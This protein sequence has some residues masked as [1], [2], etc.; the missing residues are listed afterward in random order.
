VNG[1]T[2][3]EL[4]RDYAERREEAAFAEFVRRHVD[5]VYSAALR[6]VRDGHLAEDVTQGVFVACAQNAR[7][8]SSHG[9]LLGWLHR[10]AQNLA[11][12]TVRS[13]V[14]RRAR[15]QEAMAMHELISPAVDANWENIA[16]QL[17]Q[18]LGEL[19]E[20][21]RDALWLHFFLRKSARE[22]GKTLGISDEAAQKRVSR[23]VERL[24]ELFAKRGVTVGAGGL[25]VALAAN[26]VQAAP[27]GLAAAITGASLAGTAVVSTATVTATAIK[28]MAMT[29][30]Q[31]TLFTAALVA[32]VGTGVYQ[33]REA[34]ALR[35][36]V[37]ALAQQQAPLAELNQQLTRER[38]ETSAQLAALRE[39]MA[40]LRQAAAEL[41]RL[42]GEV[43]RLREGQPGTIR[44]PS[45][46]W[47]SRR[48]RH[49]SANI[50]N[51]CR[52]KKSPS[53]NFSRRM[54]G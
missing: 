38:D 27:F 2:D 47:P 39:E 13:E 22:I 25:A 40:G 53:C 9:V 15:E 48:A 36:Q 45:R 54:T 17:D 43:T 51:R 6:M 10:T 46:H 44:L 1:R 49:N 32:A 41:P 3:Q 29:T 28:I 4:L 26:G 11:A 21:D 23:A 24:R 37:Q 5:F 34:S 8:L 14:R 30:L 12:N 35:Q 7:Q 18:A 50:W 31:K 33:M 52:I 42:R 19:S 16:P 20:A